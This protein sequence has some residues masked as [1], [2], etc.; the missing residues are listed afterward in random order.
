MIAVTIKWVNVITAMARNNPID[1]ALFFRLT[2]SQ[3]KKITYGTMTVV[4]ICGRLPALK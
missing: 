4:T 1:A 3:R 2:N